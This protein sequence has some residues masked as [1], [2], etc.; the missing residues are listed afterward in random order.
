MPEAAE[1]RGAERQARPQAPSQPSAAHGIDE[2]GH[3][4]IDHALHGPPPLV[5]PP[6]PARTRGEA[7]RGDGKPGT[8][9]GGYRRGGSPRGR[10]EGRAQNAAGGR[11]G[12]TR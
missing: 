8:G 1:A 3:G 12:P 9:G 2:L 7:A 4:A 5:A 6:P 11:T 10:R